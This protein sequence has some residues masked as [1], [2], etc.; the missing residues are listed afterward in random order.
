VIARSKLP[1]AYL[2]WN[3][4]WGAPSG[5]K[6]I[7]KLVRTSWRSLPGLAQAIGPFGFQPNNSIRGYEYPWAYEMVAPKPG[8]RIVDVGGGLSGFQFT[9][10]RAGAKVFNVDPGEAARGRGWPVDEATIAMLNARFGTDVVLKPCFL[11]DVDLE[12]G[13]IDTM[14]SIS[15]M[16]HIP[17]PDLRSLLK[18]AHALLKPGGRFVITMDLFLDLAPFTERIENEWGTNISVRELVESSGLRLVSGEKSELNGYP[19]LEP[20][21]IKSK[22]PSYLVGD[23]HPALAQLFILRKA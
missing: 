2:A 21:A 16:E 19:E 22:V 11:Q 13:T 4:T 23:G 8:Q 1:D 5:R 10:S 20:A 15:V 9:L 14:V 7:K 18:R 6:A 17:W 12:D 3:R